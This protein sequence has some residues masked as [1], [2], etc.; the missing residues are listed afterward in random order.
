MK[1]QG[2]TLEESQALLEA[3]DNPHDIHRPFD[4]T[5]KLQNTEYYYISKAMKEN[6]NNQTKAAKSLGIRRETLIHKLKKYALL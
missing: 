2:V 5:N 1:E 3:F 4:L 6:D